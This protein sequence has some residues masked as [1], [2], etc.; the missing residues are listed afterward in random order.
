MSEEFSF[1]LI[2]LWKGGKAIIFEYRISLGYLRIVITSDKKDG[3][4]DIQCLETD[5]IR[6]KT[7]WTDC[8]LKVEKVEY[9]T[10]V[11]IPINFIIKD[12][13][14]DFEVHCG[15]ISITELD[16]FNDLISI[17]K[18]EENKGES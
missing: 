5:Y 6:G 15:M 14:V 4:L 12:T 2:D 16:D 10:D 1:K 18:N 13:N 8:N 11:G 9:K 3:C 17:S 7:R